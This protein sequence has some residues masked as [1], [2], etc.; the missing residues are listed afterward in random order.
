MSFLFFS[1]SFFRGEG[2]R[3]FNGRRGESKEGRTRRRERGNGNLVLQ[4]PGGDG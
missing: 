3:G 4:F 1:H 2:K